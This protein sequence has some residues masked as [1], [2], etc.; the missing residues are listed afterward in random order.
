MTRS[1]A[2]DIKKFTEDVTISISYEELSSFYRTNGH[3]DRLKYIEEVSY[4]QSIEFEFG[5]NLII[6]THQIHSSDP[7][8]FRYLYKGNFT[9]DDSEVLTNATFNEVSVAYY[10][11]ID[12]E[13]YGGTHSPINSEG[14][15][16]VWLSTQSFIGWDDATSKLFNSAK[17]DEYQK[18]NGEI[19]EEGVINGENTQYFPTRWYETPFSNNLID[20]SELAVDTI[21]TIG[22]DSLQGSTRIDKAFLNEGNDIFHGLGGN[23]IIYGNKGNDTLYGNAGNDSIFA[24]KNNDFVFGGKG[25]DNIYGNTGDDK[26]YGNLDDDTIYGGQGDDIVYAGQGNDFIYGNKGNDLLWGNKGADT[27]MIT[28]GYDI[29]KDFWGLDGD[30]VSVATGAIYNISDSNG[31]TLISS[32]LGQILL[33]GFARDFFDEQNNLIFR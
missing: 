9:Y 3:T 27:F 12:G 32:G 30:K 10:D 19:I 18:T 25:S 28:Q 21:G 23:D 5:D 4:P 1:L 22:D 33:E 7:L 14:Q 17:V 13:E 11:P 2:L 31:S 6:A 29:V 20:A 24:G 16:V 26:I 15:P 8:I